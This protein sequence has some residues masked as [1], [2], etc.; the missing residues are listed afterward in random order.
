DGAE[1][2]ALTMQHLRMA[3]IAAAGALTAAGATA[4]GASCTT[5]PTNVPVRTFEQAQKVDVVCIEV[6]DSSGN[7][8][9]APIPTAEDQC[10]PVPTGVSGAS[11]P[12]HLF[13]VVTQT[14]PGEL[15]V[16]DLTAGGI[17]DEDRSTPGIN[18]IPVG[19]SPTD[20]AV[21]PD[22]KFTYV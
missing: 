6:N 18:F 10:T 8:L 5:T 2:P 15:A 19:A 13:A 21:T 11:L 22:G 14:T 17:V 12:N 16:V 20:V 9:A 7:A 3:G 4:I 1:G